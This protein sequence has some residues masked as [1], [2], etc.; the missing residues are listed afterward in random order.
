MARST[1]CPERG[2]RK[3]VPVR[4][5]DFP[6]EM[7]ALTAALYLR[8]TDRTLREWTRERRL[9]CVKIGRRTE[10]LKRDLD[11]FKAKGRIPAKDDAAP[12][13]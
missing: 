4:P 1:K 13:A 3:D 9:A 5:E 7:D 11:D 12:A 2:R 6:E 8:V 10:Y